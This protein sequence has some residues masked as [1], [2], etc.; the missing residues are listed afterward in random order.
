M[1]DNKCQIMCIPLV[2]SKKLSIQEVIWQR[3]KKLGRILKRRKNYLLNWIDEFRGKKL[4]KA[5]IRSL[6]NNLQPGD[7][8][9][10]RSQKEIKATLN[11]WDELYRCGIMEEMLQYCG[12]EQG[13]LKRIVKFLDERDYIVKKCEGIVILDSVL[14]NGTIDFGPCDRACFYF[15]REEWLEKI[16]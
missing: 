11:R 8:V 6:R 3:I 4:S 7:R 2:V 12:S 14:C 5:E 13:V 10:I 15:W 1:A 16:E 9:R